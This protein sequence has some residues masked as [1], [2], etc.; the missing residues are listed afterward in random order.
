MCHLRAK[1][2]PL[3]LISVLTLAFI[4]AASEPSA[5][6]FG[7]YPGYE[8]VQYRQ[9]K[10]QSLHVTA[11]DGTKLAIDVHLPKGLPPDT[12]L[13]TIMKVTRYW[14]AW[15]LRWPM[16][17][18]HKDAFV[19]FY[20]R[21]GYAVVTMD[22]RGTGAS[23]GT[24]SLPYT[25]QEALDSGGDVVQWIIEQ[26]WSNGKVGAQ[27]VSYQGNTSAMLPIANHPA[28]KAV[29]PR[30]IEFDEYTDLPFPGGICNT[31]F[32]RK[33]SEAT[34]AMDV[35]DTRKLEELFDVGWFQRWV[36]K[37]IR[38]VD[39]DRRRKLLR[40]AAVEHAGNGD[41]MAIANSVDYRDDIPEGHTNNVEDISL[42][43]HR[44]AVERSGVAYYLW[45]SW[46][47]ACTA[48]S[49][50]HHFFTYGNPQRAVIG[51]WNHGARHDADQFNPADTAVW[52]S[53]EDQMRDCLRFF[54]HHLKDVDTGVMSEKI[55]HYYTI[56]ESQ[57]KTTAVWP[58]EGMAMQRWFL[59][60]GF[61]LGKQAPSTSAGADEY[62]IDFTATTGTTNCWHT[63]FGGGDVVYDQRREQLAKTLS[64]RS[65][66]LT[67]SMEITG[68][69]V[70][71]LHVRSTHEDGAFYVY[72]D[73]EAPDGSIVYI[74]DGQLRALHRKVSDEE[75]P[76]R[77]W[78]PYHTFKR[79]DGAPM[80]PGEVT[81][82]T[83]GLLP[84]SALIPEGYRL[85]V[86][87][88]GHDEDN[89]TRYPAEGNP[90]ITVERNAAYPSCI[91]L[92]VVGRE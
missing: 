89:F 22:V 15:W 52:P 81:E 21:H 84:T 67:E 74:T 30:F 24:C 33:F 5:K 12:K 19:A 16:S 80:A 50:L 59:T 60:D 66:P 3:L 77:T 71:T 45:G 76:Y 87:I 54:D 36:I 9:F 32:I 4:A 43:T 83:F 35:H 55:L 69:P 62:P 10:T 27:G 85:R 48:N 79:A 61:G 75:P 86:S 91:D 6:D 72:L 38:P 37:G 70:V 14:R 8:G 64:Y 18:K 2:F 90:V 63:Q 23:F 42:H 92:P 57:W 13:P 31:G 40:A 44:E 39:G 53:R 49:T 7:G 28:V 47:D 51:A 41:L 56:G 1:Y 17:L 73:A 46:T 78:V 58:P 26:P 68:H 20:T 65:E 82:V 34:Q 25:L 88:A 11:K 29:V